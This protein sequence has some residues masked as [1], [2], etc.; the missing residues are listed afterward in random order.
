MTNMTDYLDSLKTHFANTYGRELTPAD[1]AKEFALL[2][3]AHRVQN[4]GLLRTPEAMTLRETAE[5]HAY[6][7]AIRKVHDQLRRVGR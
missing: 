2:P 6:E 7:R 1:A 3:A 5:R 4:L